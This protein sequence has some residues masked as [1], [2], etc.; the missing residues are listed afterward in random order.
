MQDADDAKRVG[1]DLEE[2]DVVAVRAGSNP[3]AQFVA[4]TVTPR[5]D[6]DAI[7]LLAKLAHKGDGASR[8]VSGDV[9]ADGF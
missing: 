7:A 3:I 8:V 6:G 1:F 9:V 4:L 2:D 5:I